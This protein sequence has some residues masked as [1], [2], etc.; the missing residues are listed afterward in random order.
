MVTNATHKTLEKQKSTT[1]HLYKKEDTHPAACLHKTSTDNSERSHRESAGTNRPHNPPFPT[2]YRASD[3]QKKIQTVFFFS[4]VRSCKPTPGFPPH[5][6]KTP[7]TGFLKSQTGILP[8]PFTKKRAHRPCK[9]FFRGRGEHPDSLPSKD[10]R[11]SLLATPGKKCTARS[12]F[13]LGRCSAG[14]MPSPAE[15]DIRGPFLFL[16]DAL[17]G[18]ALFV[19]PALL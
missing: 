2:S 14:G 9:R 8:G 16:Y 11:R 10:C 1:T 15:K 18:E 13:F 3:G 7:T 4:A 17:L 19:P 5:S 12:L 6:P